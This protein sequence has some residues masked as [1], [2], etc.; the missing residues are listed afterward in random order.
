MED[1]EI[2]LNRQKT[3]RESMV[4]KTW[5]T[6]PKIITAE[7]S[8]DLFDFIKMVNKLVDIIMKDDK[9]EFIPDE[10]TT[11]FV[12]DASKSIEHPYITYEVV[13]RVPKGELKPRV[14][15]EIEEKDTDPNDTRPGEIYGQKFECLIQFNVWA[16]AYAN[17]Q[18]LMEKFEDMMIMYAGFFKRNGVAEL[19]FKRQFT[20]NKFEVFR[21][22]F[23]IR[24]IQYYVEIE[25][26]T[27]I[28]REKIK[29]IET[30]SL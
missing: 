30:M 20:D 24:N 9:V 22:T 3:V 8:A 19:M 12:A 25:K 7:K 28:F 6:Q 11:K 23:S 29:E 5:Q 13:N 16:G 18:E 14:R 2:L 15:Q 17:A 1:L 27:V 4:D 26:L 10:G 21:Q